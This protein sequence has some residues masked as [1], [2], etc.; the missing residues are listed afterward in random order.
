MRNCDMKTLLF[1]LIMVLV[2][3]AADADSG[4]SFYAPFDGSATATRCESGAATP[5]TGRGLTFVPGVTGQAV[6]VGGFGKGP[7]DQMPLLEYD[8]GR[9]FS[10]DG[11]TVMFWV[12]PDWDGYFTDPIK[13]DTHFLFGAVGGRDVPDFSTRDVAA[14]SGTGRIWLFMWNWLRLDLHEQP[15]KP[16]PSAAWRCRNTWMRGDWWHVAMTWQNKGWSKL[17]VNGIPQAIQAQP[18]LADI[19]R[20]YVG[21]LPKVWNQTQR[22]DAAFDE[23]S[24]YPAA[25]SDEA[26]A[27]EFRR[28][29]PLDF[30]LER[31]YLR[32]EQPEE[33]SIEIA[34]GADVYA[35]VTGTLLVRVLADAGGRVVVEKTFP[36]N[37]S[38]RQTL[39]LPVGRLAQGAYRAECLLT[40]P[41]GQFRRSFPL[42]VYQQQPA[43]AVSRE[44]VKL[45]ERIVSIDCTKGDGLLESPPSQVKT[46]RGGES[47]REAGANKWDRFGYE[48]RVPG[49]DGSPVMLEVTWPDD[50]ERAMSFYMLPKSASPQHRDRLSG[51]VQCGGEY[52]G[53]GTMQ[54]ARY[55]FYPTEEQYLFEVRTLVPGLPAA[56]SK[57]EVYRL[58]ERLPRLAVKVPKGLP[59]R[60]L[61]HLD[62]D[63]SFEVLFGGPQ[64]P[65]F[66]RSPLPYGYPIQ[67]FERLLDYMDYTGQDM[68]SYSLARYTW[69]HLD[70][71]PVNDVGDGMRV[72]GWVDL[73]LEMMGQRGK[74]LLAN[75]NVWTIP[76]QGVSEDQTEARLKAD[77]YRLDRTGKATGAGWNGAGLRDNPTHPAVRA[78]FLKLVGEMC[79]RYGKYEAFGGLDLWCGNA[80]PYLHGSSDYGYDD[81]TVAAFERETGVKVPP[82]ADPAE[83]YAVRYKY[84]TGEKRAQWLAWRARRNTELLKQAEAL[85]RETRP[86]L[87]L[88]ISISG[89]YDNSPAFLDAEQGEDFDFAKFAYENCG[90]DL[91]ALKKLPSVTLAPMEDGTYYRWLKHWY[92]GRE[93]ITNEL[94][95]NVAKFGVLRNGARSGTAIYLR[96]FESFME[97]LKQDTYN[98]YFQNSD[99][100]AHGR[101]FLQDFATALASQDAS[102]I[103]I[104]AQPLGTTGRDA[105][106]REFASAYRALP[107][108]DFKDVAGLGDPVTARYLNTAAGTYVYAV[109][110][111]WTPVT[112]TLG[113]PA[114]AGAVKELATGEAVSAPGGLLEIALQPFELRSFLLAGKT[115]KPHGGRVSIPE[116][117]RGWY[118]TRL[119][120][121][122]TDVAA[123]AESGADVRAYQERLALLQAHLKAGRYAEAHRLLFSKLMRGIP[124]FRKAAADG[125]LKA[126]AAMISRSEYAVDCGSAAFYRS[127]SGRLFFPDRKYAAGGYGYDGSYQSVGRSIKGLSGTD[128]PALF[129]TEAYNLDAYRFTVK[130]GKYTVRLHLK[131]GYEPGAKPGVFVLSVDL[132]G[133]RALSDLDLFTACG[134]DFTKALVREFK[135]VEVRDGVLDIEFSI[136][137]GRSI[138]PTA[139]LCDA[140]EVLPQD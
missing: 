46:A 124:E 125:S 15:G 107:V 114:G 82:V 84:L 76:A 136:P 131:V 57:L 13:F 25:L 27:G 42:T 75:I 89:W 81:L 35:P 44:D 39:R 88:C 79:R 94:N 16:L 101:Y 87:K 140:I 40:R 71:G 118:A 99:P 113:L 61:G 20:F 53:S 91:A 69:S 126:K 123:L 23:L 14:D 19:Q 56:V 66:R 65:G 105:E 3:V 52:P 73:L 32:A 95:H 62:E 59:G 122:Q 68:M 33:F 18:K 102:Q 127:K 112:A 30:T 58:A 108:G 104:G 100:K 7:Y 8:G 1:G 63:Q 135:D 36:L 51:G 41:Q 17:Y 70:E 9:H 137:A 22:A 48:V 24:I 78:G 64:D 120:E 5:T 139:R 121:L 116:A 92:G 38:K 26:I 80:T 86:G 96:Y 72:A 47:Y 60:A 34:P 74:R 4:P 111:L 130:P 138:D 109:N 50:R 110:L 85:V 103:L 117:T 43:P 93:N 83:R 21:S 2:A 97:S 134:N 28:I 10:G 132:E 11:G 119:A 129:A 55:L 128:D 54:K 98:G 6:Y 45:G 90:L 67:T 29:A 77:Y 106:T 37:L 12:S 115:S 133:Q 31:R 49:A